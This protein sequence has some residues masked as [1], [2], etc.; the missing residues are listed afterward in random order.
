MCSTEH[1]KRKPQPNPKPHHAILVHVMLHCCKAFILHAFLILEMMSSFPSLNKTV[2]FLCFF[3]NT[4][5]TLN[6]SLYLILKP[7]VPSWPF[8]F[9]YYSC[10]QKYYTYSVA[11]KFF[12]LMLLMLKNTLLPIIIIKCYYMV[13]LFVQGQGFSPS[14]T[15]T[16]NY[17]V[18]YKE[19]LVFINY[20]QKQKYPLIF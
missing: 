17:L 19:P 3:L 14:P 6:W 11:E 8:Y 16:L 9:T 15:S 1:G 7:K 5:P 4:V 13:L 20:N 10:T 12:L 2:F 18:V